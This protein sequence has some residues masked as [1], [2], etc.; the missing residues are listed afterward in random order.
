MQA[1]VFSGRQETPSEHSCR[2]LEKS[3]LMKQHRKC[4]LLLNKELQSY[5][6]QLKKIQLRNSGIQLGNRVCD[7]RIIN[8]HQKN[9]AKSDSVAVTLSRSLPEMKH[10]P[11]ADQVW[12]A[13]QEARQLIRK[14]I[15]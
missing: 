1:F 6:I 10:Y 9:C 2:L 12:A 5:H 8:F 3:L 7:H 14:T 15:N 13:I 4:H 11:T